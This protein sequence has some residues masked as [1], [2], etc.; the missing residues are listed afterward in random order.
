MLQQL[1]EISKS[2][3]ILPYKIANSPLPSSPHQNNKKVRTVLMNG[4]MWNIQNMTEQDRQTDGVML[5]DMFEVVEKGK[6]QA[7]NIL[8]MKKEGPK[9]RMH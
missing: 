7:W 5:V 9:L 2:S 6:P 1:A 8:R 4:K 3:S